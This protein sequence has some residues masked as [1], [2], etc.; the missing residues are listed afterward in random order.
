MT[1]KVA[2]C[3]IGIVQQVDE[4]LEDWWSRTGGWNLYMELRKY[5]LGCVDVK[6]L[7]VIGET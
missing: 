4:I 7:N 6:L 1:D 3:Q 5:C 2:S